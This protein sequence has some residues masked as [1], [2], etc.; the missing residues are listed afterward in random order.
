MMTQKGKSLRHI[1]SAELE[2]AATAQIWILGSCE[3]NFEPIS[4]VP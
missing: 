1:L 2:L 3:C 4:T